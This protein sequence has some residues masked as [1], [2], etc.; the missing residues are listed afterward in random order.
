VPSFFRL[1]GGLPRRQCGFTL[2]ELMIVVVIIGIIASVAYPS[3]TRYVERGRLSD[4]KAGLM[5]AATEMERCYSSN[6]SYEADCLE[7]EQSPEKVYPDITLTDSGSTYRLEAQNGTNV[8][9]SCETLW[10]ES[11]GARGPDGCW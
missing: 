4:G 1:P 7:T 2:I 8:P 10:I 3:Y 6:Y 5:Q 9:A 11:D